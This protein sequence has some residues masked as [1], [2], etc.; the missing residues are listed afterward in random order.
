MK[1]FST[2]GSLVDLEFNYGTDFPRANWIG[3]N[4]WQMRRGGYLCSKVHGSGWWV[5]AS[6]QPRWHC[7]NEF[8]S[9][10]R[11]DG[12]RLRFKTLSNESR[13]SS[14]SSRGCNNV[15]LHCHDGLSWCELQG[16]TFWLS[17]KKWTNNTWQCTF[18]CRGNILYLMKIIDFRL[19]GSWL[20]NLTTSSPSP[21]PSSPSTAKLWDFLA[22]VTFH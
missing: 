9:K 13:H 20:G 1:V 8:I 15:G 11:V 14:R 18:N 19:S 7:A 3:G 12:S 2:S 6:W 17:D 5:I 22:K 21:S 4:L 10:E 16:N